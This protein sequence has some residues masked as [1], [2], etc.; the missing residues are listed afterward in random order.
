MFKISYFSNKEE[1]FSLNISAG[2]SGIIKP[3]IP[4][5]LHFLQNSSTPNCNIGLKYPMII[6]G[7]SML[8]LILISWLKR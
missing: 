1:Y 4:T 7:I 6:K 8:S 5:S 3:S 2:R